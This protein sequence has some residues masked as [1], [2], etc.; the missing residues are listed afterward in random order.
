ML[1]NIKPS[2]IWNALMLMLVNVENGN[3]ENL[4]KISQ[5]KRFLNLK[6]ILF[7]FVLNR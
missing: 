3:K 4:Y 6:K 2:S 1:N 7:S 5:K